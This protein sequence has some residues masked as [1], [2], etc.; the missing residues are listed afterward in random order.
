MTEQEFIDK[1]NM[2]YA[3][4]KKLFETDAKYN[5]K[6][7]T[8]HSVSGYVEDIFSLYMAERLDNPNNFYL[9]DKLISLRFSK[10]GKAT[11]FKPDLAIIQ[12]QCLTH[13]YDLKT[14]LGWNRELDK[15]LRQKDAFIQKIKGRKGWVYFEKEN[16]PEIVFSTELKYQMVVF[17]GWNINQ[18]LLAKNIELASSLDNVDLH[19]LN[20]WDKKEN[21]LSMDKSAFDCLHKEIQELV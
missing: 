20:I 17:S 5:I 4:A 18:D 13:Y 6:R 8:A 1:I 2:K 9:V 12:N 15:Y 7:G 14:N 11:T 10:N 21:S 16:R 19:I 3:E